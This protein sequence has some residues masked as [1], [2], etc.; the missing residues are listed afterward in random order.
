MLQY[1]DYYNQIALYGFGA[2][3]PPYYKCLGSCFA[4][5]GNYYHPLI[6]GGV[7]EIIRLYR[8]ALARIQPH[9]PTKLSDIISMAMQFA[10]AEYQSSNYY[11]LI[12]LT[13]GCFD[14]FDLTV[15]HII[16]A[17]TLPLSI[18]MVGLGDGDFSQLEKLDQDEERLKSER[19]GK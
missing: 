14:D 10:Q 2:K 7:D 6:T 18:V 9:G 19:T 17:S 16:E 12:I 1:F 3:L 8:E 11:V 5:N 15:D 13:D 4:L